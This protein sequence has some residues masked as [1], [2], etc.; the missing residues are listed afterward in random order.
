MTS[1]PKLVGAPIARILGPLYF[2]ELRAS[3][4]FVQHS[5]LGIGVS[6]HKKV[7]R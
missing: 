4:T 1:R 5:I 6:L 7:G 3:G 2:V